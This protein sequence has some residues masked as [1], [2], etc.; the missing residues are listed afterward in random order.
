[1]KVKNLCLFSLNFIFLFTTISFANIEENEQIDLNQIEQEI[2][3]TS[4]NA[5]NVLEINSRSAIVFD[6]ASKTI[7]FNKNGNDV[8][9]MASTTKIMTAIVVI[10]STNLYDTITVS[11]KAASTG[12]SRLGIKEGDKI[13]VCDLLYGLLLKSRK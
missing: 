3:Q 7:L 1:M 13:T 8:R 9:K 6:R 2:I 5:S 12:G 4:T 11:K 10:E